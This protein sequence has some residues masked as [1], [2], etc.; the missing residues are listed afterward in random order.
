MTPTKPG[1]NSDEAIQ[2]DAVRALVCSQAR[3]V[4][5]SGALVS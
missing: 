5:G 4:T 3:A 1:L 2:V